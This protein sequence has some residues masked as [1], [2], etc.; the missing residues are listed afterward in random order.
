MIAEVIT[1]LSQT[2]A[3]ASEFEYCLYWKSAN[4]ATLC[5]LFYDHEIETA[6][7]ND[8][9][10]QKSTEF[11]GNVFP[12]EERN[13]LLVAENLT[14]NE[15]QTIESIFRSKKIWR[16]NKSTSLNENVAIN[17]KRIG[18]R[19]SDQRY[20]IEIEVTLPERVLP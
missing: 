2:D 9:I 7:D 3:N 16:Y 8:V 17:K 19:K 6:I 11:I 4:G 13:V 1:P 5:W 10:N 12:G 14:K 18:Q 20:R 15:F